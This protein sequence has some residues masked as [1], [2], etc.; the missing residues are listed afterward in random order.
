MS[1]RTEREEVNLEP[2]E[3]VVEV[4]PELE[5]VE[6]I[7]CVIGHVNVAKLNVRVAPVF[8]AEV[9]TIIKENTELEIGLDESTDEFYKVYL[10]NGVDGF[11]MM[12][13]PSRIRKG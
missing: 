7:E 8:D 3:D 12:R 6:A 5:E 9:V 13:Y 4:E 11:C 2:M 10:A 1:K